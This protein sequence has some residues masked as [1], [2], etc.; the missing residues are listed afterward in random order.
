MIARAKGLS[1]VALVAAAWSFPAQAADEP[2]PAVSL[3]AAY[4]GDLMRNT[5]GGLGRGGAYLD[6]FDLMATVDGGQAFGVDG[7]TLHGHVMYNNGHA[8]SGRWV[9]DAQ[10]ISNIEGVDTWRLYEFWGELRF[11]AS[12]R[13]TLRAGLYDLNSEFDSIETAGL[14]LNS[15]HGI[16][17]DLAQTGE[18]GPSIFPVTSLALRLQGG[19]AD[20]YWQLAALDAVPGEPGH[21]DRTSFE[22]GGG[23]GAL[24]IGE[25]GR[26][27]GPFRKLALG[28]WTYTAKFAAIGE[29]DAAGDPVRDTG[30]RGFYAIAETTLAEREG[31]HATG[32]VRAGLADDRFNGFKNYVGLG[33]SAAG[34]VPGRPD[35]QLGIALASV[36]AGGPWRDEMALA[37]SATDARETT[38]ELTWRLPVADWLTLQPDLQYVINP[39]FDASLDDAFVVGLRFELG[40]SWT[41]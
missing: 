30:N 17:P 8:F 18:N 7:L 32:W 21:P 24:L 25:F 37:G 27:V 29:T 6:N 38:L 15:S 41:R 20:W 34:L 13:T 23:E 9:G 33:A 19:A 40:S 12:G 26:A 10:G 3:E 1:A 4:V 35:D 5:Q 28:A 16:G 11:G 2:S 31:L 36:A 22:L 39:G 14:F